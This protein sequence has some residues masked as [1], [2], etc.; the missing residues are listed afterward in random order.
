MNPVR[1]LFFPVKDKELDFDYHLAE[2]G[3]D[4]D[5][6]DDDPLVFPRDDTTSLYLEDKARILAVRPDRNDYTALAEGERRTVDAAAKWLAKVLAN[7]HHDRES[8]LPLV[9]VGRHLVE[10]FVIL[11]RDPAGDDHAV[12]IHVCFPS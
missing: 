2:L 3:T 9:D 6:S 4:F 11:H 5:N 1:P 12:W 7:E 10:D 8:L